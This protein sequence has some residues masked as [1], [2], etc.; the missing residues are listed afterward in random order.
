MEMGR[1]QGNFCMTAV[2]IKR[3]AKQMPPALGLVFSQN[4][5]LASP[6]PHSL[7]SGYYFYAS[8]CLLRDSN[9]SLC[10]ALKKC[11]L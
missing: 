1:A 4:L 3:F 9:H 7:P 8:F 2:Q 5:P 10:L 6:P 11:D